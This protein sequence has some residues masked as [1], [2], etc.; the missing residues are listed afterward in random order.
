[1]VAHLTEP[2]EQILDSELGISGQTRGR[3]FW[4]LTDRSLFGLDARFQSGWHWPLTSL[5]Y[6]RGERGQLSVKTVSGAEETLTGIGESRGLELKISEIL[7]ALPRFEGRYST[8]EG[9]GTYISYFPWRPGSPAS[10]R[11]GIDETLTGQQFESVFAAAQSELLAISQGAEV[12]AHVQI[13]P[14]E[15]AAR[16]TL[17]AAMMH[18]FE[19]EPL[20][21]ASVFG[22]IVGR[23]MQGERRLIIAGETSVFSVASA[24]DTDAQFGAPGKFDQLE[25]QMKAV[26][27]SDLLD[28]QDW[29]PEPVDGPPR[30][31]F[32]LWIQPEGSSPSSAGGQIAQ[33]GLPAT[34]EGVAVRD[35]IVSGILSGSTRADP[36]VSPLGRDVSLSPHPVAWRQR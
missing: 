13:G 15:Q 35:K 34:D 32:R 12:P 17:V 18:G 28:W 25:P 14:I 4:V 2:G 19:Q 33:L 27:Y 29:A 6:F 20:D 5:S 10:W 24:F 22:H 36:L 9:S 16:G 30:F 3:S 1:M 8:R 31:L 23:N 11:F 7:S 26:P 21:P